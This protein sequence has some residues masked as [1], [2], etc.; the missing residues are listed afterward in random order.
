[1]RIFNPPGMYIQ[2]QDWDG[3]IY[4]LL[5]EEGEWFIYKELNKN[6][7]YLASQT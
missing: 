1:V 2:E 6:D 5:E 3:I 4:P 7:K